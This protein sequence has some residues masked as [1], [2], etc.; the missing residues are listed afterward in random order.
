MKIYVGVLLPETTEH[1]LKLLFQPY[2]HVTSVFIRKENENGQTTLYGLVDMPVKKQALAAIES[3]DGQEIN[4]YTLSV[5]PARM[6]RRNRRRLGR[7]GGRRN[8]DPSDEE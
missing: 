3:L 1:E 4:G 7:V 2:G 6:G 8:Y 5:H